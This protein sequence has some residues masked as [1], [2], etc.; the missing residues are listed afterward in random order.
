[1][2]PS[3]PARPINGLL[4]LAPSG[5]GKSVFARKAYGPG[6]GIPLIDGDDVMAA[7]GL[8]P[9]NKQ[10]WK[11][12]ALAAAVTGSHVQKLAEVF[13]RNRDAI[14]LFNT[15][16]SMVVPTLRRNVVGLDIVFISLPVEQLRKNWETR[17]EMIVAGTSGH[18]SRPWE[19]YERALRK[20]TT[21]AAILG[22]PIYKGFDEMASAYKLYVRKKPRASL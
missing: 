8:W 17:E 7:S 1:M 4:V 5:S 12:P 6:T 20:Q 13:L 21:E 9:D 18:S 19:E 22:I 16:M 2:S 15:K 11:D 3:A 14:V 10:W